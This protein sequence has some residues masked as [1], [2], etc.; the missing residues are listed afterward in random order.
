MKKCIYQ[1]NHSCKKVKMQST[2]LHMNVFFLPLSH[3]AFAIYTIQKRQELLLDF[4][5]PHFPAEGVQICTLESKL[6]LSLALQDT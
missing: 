2:D 3:C 4:K 5:H 1:Y 6:A